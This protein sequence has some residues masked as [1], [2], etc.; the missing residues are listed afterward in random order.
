MGD[1]TPLPKFQR[2]GSNVRMDSVRMHRSGPIHL[3]PDV[4]ERFGEAEYLLPLRNGRSDMVGLR[5]TSPLPRTSML[6]LTACSGGT[7]SI[8]GHNI[9]TQARKSKPR[10]AVELPHHWDGDVLVLDLSGLPDATGGQ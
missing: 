8:S 4:V 5:A 6:K 10:A 7:R 9:L 2:K 3:S 1:W